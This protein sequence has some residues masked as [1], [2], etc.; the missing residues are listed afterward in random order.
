MAPAGVRIQV[1]NTQALPNN[2]TRTNAQA[3]PPCEADT[4]RLRWRKKAK[5]ENFP[6]DTR[7]ACQ[8]QAATR[9]G[10]IYVWALDAGGAI[11]TNAGKS[12]QQPQSPKW[13]GAHTMQY[14][15]GHKSTGATW[16][17]EQR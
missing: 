9:N 17:A 16:A 2:G 4:K 8:R 10:R 12:K 15:P 13:H 1:I 6:N 7:R 11:R 3:V 14:G 5:A